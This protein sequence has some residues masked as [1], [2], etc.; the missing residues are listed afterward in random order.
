MHSRALLTDDEAV[1]PV[2]GVVLMVAIT[3]ILAA[4]IASFVLGLGQETTDTSPQASFSVEFTEVDANPASTANDWGVVRISHDAGDEINDDVLYV[5]GSGFNASGDNYKSSD[6]LGDTYSSWS[7][8]LQAYTD[9]KLHMTDSG[10]WMG[11]KSGTDSAVTSGDEVNVYA[12]SAYEI[13]VVWQ[14]QQT[15]TSSTLKEDAGPDA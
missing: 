15:D 1:A 10:P 2:I 11:T 3:V 5:R 7:E 13:D 14:S 9:S 8:S 6:P 4:V 12:S